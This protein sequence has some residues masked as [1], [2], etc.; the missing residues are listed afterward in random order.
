MDFNFVKVIDN[1]NIYVKT[2]E[3]GCGYTYGCGTGMTASA[4]ISNYFDKTSK[5]VRVVSVGGAVDIKITNGAIYMLGTAEKVYE[6]DM[7]I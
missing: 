1:N 3:R 5:N 4:I 7:W 2:W 6:G